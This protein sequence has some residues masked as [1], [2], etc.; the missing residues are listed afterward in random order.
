MLGVKATNM[1]ITLTLRGEE[2][3]VNTSQDSRYIDTSI[4]LNDEEGYLG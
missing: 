3:L 4:F 2:I 1:E